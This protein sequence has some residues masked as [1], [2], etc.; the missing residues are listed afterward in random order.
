MTTPTMTGAP[1]KTVLLDHGQGESAGTLVL[2]IKIQVLE[3][4]YFRQFDTK[5]YFK[6]IELAKWNSIFNQQGQK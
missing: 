1:G 4:V 3:I 2:A 6:N 5:F